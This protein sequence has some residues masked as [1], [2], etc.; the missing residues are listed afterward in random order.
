MR[1]PHYDWMTPLTLFFVALLTRLPFTSKLLYNLDSV[2]FALA[3]DKYDIY[4]HQPQ[5]PGYFLYVMLGQA[6][7]HVAHDAHTSYLVISVI[8]SGLTVVAVYYLGMA[9]FNPET[10]RWAALL[11]LTSPLLWFY[12]EIAS[13]Y[14]VA[15]FFNTWIALLFWRLWH[16]EHK[17]LYPSAIILGIAA[18]IRQELL[19]F[20]FPLWFFCLRGLAWHKILGA[21]IMLGM[22]VGF[23]FIPMLILT[24]GPERYFLAVHEEWDSFMSSFTVWNAGLASRTVF[25]TTLAKAVS[26]GIGMGIIFLP[27]AL[28]VRLRMGSWRLISRD[29]ILFFVLWLLPAFL[30]YVFIFM[31]PSNLTFGFFFIPAFLVLMYPS[32]E[33]AASEGKR[34]IRGLHPAVRSICSVTLGMIILVNAGVFLL[35]DSPVSASQIRRHD[36]DLSTLLSGIEKNFPAQRTIVLN[37]RAYTLFSYRHIQYYLPDYRT[38]LADGPLHND[39]GERWHVF[40]GIHRETFFSDTIEIP[41]TARYVVHFIDPSDHEYGRELKA[42]HIQ[43][44]SLDDHNVLFYEEIK[45]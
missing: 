43:R 39:R 17:W 13:P 16:H 3:L 6:I 19:I 22:T 24:G 10:G 23:W 41:P 5:P 37:D 7:N 45:R 29:K 21:L 14:V 34:L 42:K 44:L 1:L 9:L 18:G 38:Y 31:Q 4:R 27:F 35:T 36:R 11:A 26:Y 30:F 15:A 25:L 28:Y 32:I 40:G 12:G 2:H 33:Y 8:F 20:L